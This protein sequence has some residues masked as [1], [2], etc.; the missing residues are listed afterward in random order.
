MVNGSQ[1]APTIATRTATSEATATPHPGRR[2][3][4]VGRMLVVVVGPSVWRASCGNAVGAALI[5]YR[6]IRQPSLSSL[7]SA[8]LTSQQQYCGGRPPKT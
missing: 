8:E 2:F 5:L 1:Q 7:P 4:V 6:R 3:L